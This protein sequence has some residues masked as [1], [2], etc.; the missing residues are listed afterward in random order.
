M[1]GEPCHID[2][3]PLFMKRF[4]T[5]NLVLETA[6]F[7]IKKGGNIMRLEGKVTMLLKL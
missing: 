3:S 6:V 4:A 7:L 5:K 1:D 2:I